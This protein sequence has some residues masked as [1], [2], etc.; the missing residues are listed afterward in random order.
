[1]G[2]AAELRLALQPERRVVEYASFLLQEVIDEL[3]EAPLR[4]LGAVGRRLAN[5]QL[6]HV[7]LVAALP[8][9]APVEEVH[10]ILAHNAEHDSGPSAF[11]MRLS[12]VDVAANLR[13]HLSQDARLRQPAVQ[14]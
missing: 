10:P 14:A 4:G 8:T 11:P 2:L 5:S 12:E 9:G 7:R 13:P 6:V 1:M 3:L